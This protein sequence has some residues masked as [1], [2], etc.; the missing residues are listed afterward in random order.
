MT[1][2]FGVFVDSRWAQLSQLNALGGANAIWDPTP[3]VLAT[4][5]CQFRTH[6]HLCKYRLRL[7]TLTVSFGALPAARAVLQCTRTTHVPAGK[8]DTYNLQADSN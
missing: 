3:T 5:V 4:A 8:Q 2:L 1:A 6:D 7:G